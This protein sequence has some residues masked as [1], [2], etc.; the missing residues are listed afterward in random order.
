MTDVFA[1][2][3]YYTH[4]YDNSENTISTQLSRVNEISTLVLSLCTA[5]SSQI[6]TKLRDWAVGQAGAAATL[7]QHC[8]KMT[9]RPGT[10]L[11][12]QLLSLDVIYPK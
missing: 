9:Q 1:F 2:I 7:G 4:E 8:P 12:N 5:F 6:G 10:M 11:L 3:T